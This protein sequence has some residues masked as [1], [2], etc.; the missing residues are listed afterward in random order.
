MSENKR[1]FD[2][3]ANRKI[4]VVGLGHF[5]GGVG[6]S[7]WLCGQGAKVT[8]TDA[9]PADKLEEVFLLQPVGGAPAGE[10]GDRRENTDVSAFYE[11]DAA[12]RGWRNL[13]LDGV[14]PG[15]GPAPTP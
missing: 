11:P 13:G 3:L 9:A 10:G 5:G 7:R 1:I 14:G 4:T 6:V 8:V 15:P 12:L 2:S